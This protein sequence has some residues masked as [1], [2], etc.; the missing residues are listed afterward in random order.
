MANSCIRAVLP[1]SQRSAVKST[2][3][4]HGVESASIEETQLAQ[5]ME[6]FFEITFA[7]QR[8]S[9]LPIMRA[10][11]HAAQNDMPKASKVFLLNDQALVQR[12]G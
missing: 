12:V 9:A 10:L 6:G 8:D 4:A 11:A 1:L 5:L 7:I 3:A 2:L